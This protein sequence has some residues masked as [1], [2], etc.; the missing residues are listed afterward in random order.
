M[1]AEVAHVLPQAQKLLR[2]DDTLLRQIFFSILQ[3]H[4]PRVAN[5]V[6]VIYGM[7]REWCED[8]TDDHF[9]M[10]ATYIEK[11]QPNERVLVRL[12]RCR[13][14]GVASL[15]RWFDGAAFG[16]SHSTLVI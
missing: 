8:G 14:R 1:S 11:L 7:A 15:E 5:K 10:L 3:K 4:H 13:Q 12:M 2:D 9:E 16:R 6:D